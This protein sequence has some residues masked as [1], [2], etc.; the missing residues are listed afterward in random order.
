M[1]LRYCSEQFPA[2]FF[3][4]LTEK[5]CC[6]IFRSGKIVLVGFNTETAI[7]KAIDICKSIC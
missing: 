5:G 7:E 4:P 6:L 3:H 1:N 2:V